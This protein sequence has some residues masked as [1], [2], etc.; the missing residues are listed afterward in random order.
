MKAIN[1]ELSPAKEPVALGSSYFW[2]APQLPKGREVYPFGFY[3]D[4]DGTEKRYPLQFICQ[5]NMAE[6]HAKMG[7]LAAPLPSKGML[8]IWGTTDYF[9][10]YDTPL[11]NG[12][13][14]WPDGS[15]MAELL[16]ADP[17]ELHRRSPYEEDE[18]AIP[19]YTIEFSAGASQDTGFRLLGEPFED[20]VRQ[21]VEGTGW[22]LLMQLDSQETEHYDLMFHDMGI[23]YIFIERSR[24]EKGDFSQLRAYMTSL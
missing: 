11:Y 20:E 5:I 16:M 10:G 17:S 12:I 2:D 22:T 18:D 14:P 9:M 1:I 7:P 15:V 24:L 23:L 3:T 6:L 19:P 4:E 13:G 21:T 8:Y